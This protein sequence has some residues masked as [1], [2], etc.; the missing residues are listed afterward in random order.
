MVYLLNLDGKRS[1]WTEYFLR[2]VSF[3][4][5]SFDDNDPYFV[6]LCFRGRRLRIFNFVCLCFVLACS[7]GRSLI[8]LGT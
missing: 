7:V 3:S 8:H 4:V 1:G 6:K 2:L 5:S